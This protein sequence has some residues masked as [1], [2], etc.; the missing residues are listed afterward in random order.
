MV[1]GRGF[2]HSIT[3]YALLL[4]SYVWLALTLRA[5]GLKVRSGRLQKPITADL[6]MREQD[7][8]AEA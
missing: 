5:W 1:R 2:E 8:C 4:E 7:V 6:Q 3:S